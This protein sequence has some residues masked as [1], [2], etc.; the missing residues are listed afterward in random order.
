MPHPVSH[1]T[2]QVSGVRC[3]VSDVM[4]IYNYIFFFYK[5]LELVDGLLSTGPT[6][7][8]F[9]SPNEFTKKDNYSE[10]LKKKN[11]VTSE[12]NKLQKRAF[13]RAEETNKEEELQKEIAEEG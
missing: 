4:Y 12:L 8:T 1:V 6:P 7:S 5:V 9:I 11:I 2:S 10:V 13:K 3:Q